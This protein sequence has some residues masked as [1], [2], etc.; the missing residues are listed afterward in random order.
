MQQ[1]FN[2]KP[3]ILFGFLLLLILAAG[4]SN[5]NSS[6]VSVETAL[7]NEASVTNTIESS[8]AVAAK[9]IVKLS[10]ATSGI[11]EEIAVHNG[12]TVTSGM[13]L[14]SLDAQSAPSE[15]IKAISSLINAQQNLANIEQSTTALAE[16]KI[17]LVDAQTAYDEALKAYNGLDDPLASEDYITILQTNYLNA[18]NQ[19][20][21]AIGNY[22]RYADYEEDSVARATALANLAQARIN[23]HDALIS[24]NHFSN[25]PDYILADTIT[26]TYNLAKSNLDEAQKIYDQIKNGNLDAISKAQSAV[27]AAQATVN[28]LS[29]IA[30]IDGEVAVVYAQPGEMVSSGTKAV[31]LYDRSRMVIDVLVAEDAIST[32]K[33][34]NPATVTFSGLNIDTTG[35][36]SLIDPI[37]VSSSGVVNYTVRIE[38][39]DPD[40]QIYIGATATVIITTSDPQDKLFVAVSAVLKDAQGE[41]VMRVNNDGSTE[42]VDVITS[43]IS[44]ETVVVAG[45]LAKGDRVQVFTASTVDST[46]NQN[47]GGLFGGLGGLLR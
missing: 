19:T 40:S 24:L 42:R 45:A 26:A 5:A 35:K 27:N 47:R 15:V 37:G 41:Y 18:Q 32:V 17:A 31:V 22:N 39:D 21:R 29:I 4:C 46:T 43:D 9:Q 28:K 10:W 16:A 11:V 23:E 20:Q 12:D 2:C 6:A 8:G 7:V 38:L 13:Q 44:N 33:V 34:G 14:M 3:T 1:I 25:P 30:P 36:V